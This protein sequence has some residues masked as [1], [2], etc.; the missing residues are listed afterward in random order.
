MSTRLEMLEKLTSSGKADS[1]AWYALAL[2]YRSADRVDDALRAFEE[3]RAAYPDYVP[4][5]QMAGSMLAS[6]GREAE[7]RTWLEQGI[8]RA[9]AVGNDHARAE[10]QDMLEMMGAP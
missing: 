5:Y 9:T 3:L 7:A 6:T 8:E 10:M 1:F 2:E 4:G